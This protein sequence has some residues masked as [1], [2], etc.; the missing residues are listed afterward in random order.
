MSN[1]FSPIV[2]FTFN[3]P[4]HTKN[5]L[6]SLAL[7]NEAKESDLFIF[8]DGAKEGASD[9]IIAKIKEV[10]SIVAKEN[11][12]KSV[13][14]KIQE[15]NKGLANSIIEGVTEIVNKYGKV[16]V[17]ED[18]LVFSP[19]FLNYMND[20][21]VR[22]ENKKDV[23]QIGGCNFFANGKKY[24][25][26][27]FATMPDTW[28]WATWKDRWQHFNED[29][30]YLYKQIETNDL[31]FRFNAYGTYEMEKM[32]KDQILGKVDSWAIRWQA[33]MILNNWLCLYSNP[34]FSNHI[35]STNATHAPVNILPPLENNKP[36]FE[37]VPVVELP[38]IIEAMKK[39]Y[40]GKGDYFGNLRPK[41]K[42]RKIKSYFK[43]MATFLI[44]HGIVMLFK[45][46]K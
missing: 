20:S 12:F 42:R 40:S 25:K 5:V 7:N 33:V 41:F 43:K 36:E 18:D 9:E 14:V 34:A 46:N 23:A 27:F 2:L 32:L 8:C 16:I 10:R 26:T 28:G 37:T 1:N 21:L 17:L 6:D 11:R 13:T 30:I 22:Y 24:P 38:I 45:K 44:P 4:E 31:M 15:K 39:G 3:R 19:Y 29:A 35:E